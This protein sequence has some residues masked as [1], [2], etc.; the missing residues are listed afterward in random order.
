[1]IAEIKGRLGIVTFLNHFGVSVPPRG[2]N[3]AMTH[4][5]FHEDKAPSFAV[6]RSENRA[7]CF[8]CQ[9]GGDV[10][11]ITRLFLNCDTAG[12]VAYWR[13][14]LGLEGTA[15]MPSRQLTEAQQLQRLRQ[16]VRRKSIEVESFPGIPK[17]PAMEAHL[18][19]VYSAKEEVDTLYRKAE[20]KTELLEYLAELERWHTW[21]NSILQGAWDYWTGRAMAV[22][23]ANLKASANLKTQVSK[24]YQTI[25]QADLSAQ[26]S[27]QS[28]AGDRGVRSLAESTPE[29]TPSL[30][31]RSWNGAASILRG[32]QA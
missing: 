6:Y 1:M 22:L 2:H 12:A 25:G 13:D 3:V 5:P 20:T 28:A 19:Y 29:P 23:A 8:G 7:W 24:T 15:P 27:S 17:H 18:V 10:I 26:A 16:H 14:R 21:A 11:D 32:P 4:C 30:P 31:P 9:K